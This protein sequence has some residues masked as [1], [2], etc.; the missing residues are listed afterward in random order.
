LLEKGLADDE[1][2]ERARSAA[3]LA[4]GR[5][6]DTVVVTNEVG[7]GIVPTNALARRYRDLLGWVNSIWADASERAVLVVAGQIVSLSGADALWDDR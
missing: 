1:I 6:A 5:S 4:A 3:T 2:A 7:S